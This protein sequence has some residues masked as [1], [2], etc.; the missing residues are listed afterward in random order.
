MEFS[1]SAYPDTFARDHLPP[2][3]LWPALEFTAGLPRYPGRLN[4]AA[5]L[6]DVPAARWP[7][8]PALRTPGGIT[9]TYAELR[10]KA[11]QVARVLTEDL[12]LM[13]GNRV[14]LR[15]PNN[16][17]TVACWLGI[18]KAGGI[19]VTTFAALRA[20]ELTPIVEKTRPAIAI[21]D[22][23]L[24]GDVEAVREAVAPELVVV[25]F[26]G[27]GERGP[28]RARGGQGGPVRQRGDRRRRRR[29]VLPDLG[30]HRRPE[31]HRALPP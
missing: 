3:G 4:A 19:A 5:E 23:C 29:A 17:W 16:P 14:L 2:A 8:R 27:E 21:V 1:P 13:P 30:Q 9:W 10:A 12:G 18:L 28:D 31:G 24:A 11:N 20:R 7:A 6:I 22:H 25:P 26:G 15:S